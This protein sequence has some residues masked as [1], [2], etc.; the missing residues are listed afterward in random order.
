MNKQVPLHNLIFLKEGHV[1]VPITL[2]PSYPVLER[3]QPRKPVNPPIDQH[4]EDHLME[5]GEDEEQ[6]QQPNSAEVSAKPVSN[7]QNAIL[8]DIFTFDHC[9]NVNWRRVL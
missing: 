2:R 6:D 9:R 3:V 4:L 7:F 8:V 5:D 1:V